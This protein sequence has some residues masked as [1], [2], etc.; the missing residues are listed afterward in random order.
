MSFESRSGDYRKVPIALVNDT[1]V[2]GS[3]EIITTLLKHPYVVVSLESKWAD[4]SMDEFTSSPSAV[5]WSKYANDD[6]APLLY[7]NICRSLSDSYAA[8]SYVNKVDTFS[9][10]QKMTIRGIGSLAMYFAAS[11]VKCKYLSTM[12]TTSTTEFADYEWA[13][14]YSFSTHA[15]QTRYYRRA[16]GPR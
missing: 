16:K 8:F 11:K 6:L 7:P 12:L 13:H 9:S 2:N 3:D 14:I 1:Q 10:L 15:S 4:M 5:R